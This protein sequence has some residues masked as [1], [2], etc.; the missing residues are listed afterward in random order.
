M[1]PTGALRNLTLAL[2]AAVVV[3]GSLLFIAWKLYFRGSE[4]AG[5]WDDWWERELRELQERDPAGSA[6]RAAGAAAVGL[7]FAGIPTGMG[8]Q[9][10]S[11]W[12]LLPRGAEA[13]GS[14]APPPAQSPPSCRRGFGMGVS[15][16]PPPALPVERGGLASGTPPS[17][18]K[19]VWGLGAGGT[20]HF[21]PA[22]GQPRSV[23]LPAGGVEAGA[24]AGAGRRREEQRP[25][26]HL[27]PEGQDTHP[28][29]AGLQFCP[30]ARRGAGDGPAGG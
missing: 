8:K 27:Q 24:G 14:E 4:P 9:L 18:G 11:G 21:S 25:A 7:S 26:L 10:G 20:L 16:G 1:A 23:L 30:A 19:D 2:E 3:L 12:G 5:T 17:L 13:V 6:V 22:P 28:A 15:M 29:H